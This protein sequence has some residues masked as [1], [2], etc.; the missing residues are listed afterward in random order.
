MKKKDITNILNF[1]K[2]LVLFISSQINVLI[3]YM[4]Y[5]KTKGDRGRVDRRLCFDARGLRSIS[6]DS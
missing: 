2:I 5:N 3:V 1:M 4:C 6:E